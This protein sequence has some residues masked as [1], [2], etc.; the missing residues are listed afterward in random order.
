MNLKAVLCL[1]C[2]HADFSAGSV[3]ANYDTLMGLLLTIYWRRFQQ[4]P[5]LLSLQACTSI[6]IPRELL[7]LTG[8]KLFSY[9]FLYQ[10]FR[11]GG[12]AYLRIGTVF[13]QLIY[14][15]EDLVLRLHWWRFW[16]D[17]LKVCDSLNFTIRGSKALFSPG[18]FVI[19]NI[20]G[21]TDF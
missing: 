16:T 18:Q 8:S 21:T 15:I 5:F 20:T 10:N 6:P 4:D 2:Q 9:Q 1:S 7:S 13:R 14:C 19:S 3:P 17:L 12:S 11:S